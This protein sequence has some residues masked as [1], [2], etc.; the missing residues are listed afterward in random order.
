[1]TAGH[2]EP[3]TGEIMPDA[4]DFIDKKYGGL[5]AMQLQT[6]SADLDWLSGV[7][8]HREFTDDEP[9][10]LATAA[11]ESAIHNVFVAYTYVREEPKS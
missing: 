3:L 11:L 7:L 6:M 1:M 2:A 8:P 4:S 10:A 9:I 5:L